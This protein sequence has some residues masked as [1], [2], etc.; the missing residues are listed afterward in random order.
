MGDRIIITDE[1]PRPAPAVVVVAPEKKEKV[2][3]VVTEKTI[4]V[5]TSKN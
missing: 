4:T 5:E 3:K 2:E 1:E